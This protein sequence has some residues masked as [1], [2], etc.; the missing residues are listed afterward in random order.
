[1]NFRFRRAFT[2]IEL[3]V[4]I[5]II[6]ILAS[7]LL[8]ALAGAKSRAQQAQCLNQLKQLGLAAV[9][10]AQ[11]NDGIIQIDALPQGV[12]TWASLLSSNQGLNTLDIFLCPTYKPFHWTNWTTTYGVRRD[13]PDEYTSGTLKQFLHVNKIT[14]PT[15][16]LHLADTTSRGRSGYTAQQY[17]FFN[18]AQPKQVHARHARRANGFF[19]DGHVESCGQQRLDGLG[20]DGLFDADTAPGYF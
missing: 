9:M 15:E 20:I 11:D 1:M 5:A 19:I 18:A 8:P 14:N 16:Y 10:G 2:L 13:P 3:L 17:Y 4:V 7:L 6:G 12:K